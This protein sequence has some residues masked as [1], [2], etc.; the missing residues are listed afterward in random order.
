MHPRR[1]ARQLREQGVTGGVTPTPPIPQAE[2]AR[3]Q[4]ATMQMRFIEVTA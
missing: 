4:V 1:Y 3:A 2:A